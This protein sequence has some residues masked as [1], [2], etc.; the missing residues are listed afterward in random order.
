MK[1]KERKITVNVVNT[2][3]FRGTWKNVLLQYDNS[4]L[5]DEYN[6]ILSLF[7]VKQCIVLDQTMTQWL[8]NINKSEWNLWKLP[9]HNA[10]VHLDHEQIEPSHSSHVLAISCKD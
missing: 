4:T 2:K 8:W 3:Y 10:L 5:I 7:T 6:V 1:T 9:S